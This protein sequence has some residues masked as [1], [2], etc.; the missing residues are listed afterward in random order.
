MEFQYKQ[1]ADNSEWYI[2]MDED[3]SEY[4]LFSLITVPHPKAPKYT[5][6][7]ELIINQNYA[8]DIIENDNFSLLVKICRFTFDSILVITDDNN[9]NECKI[10]A[11]DDL[12][13]GIYKAFA[14]ALGQ[15]HSDYEVT[16]YRRWIV[17]KKL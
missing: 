15:E 7:L 1:A 13:L 6:H 3:N 11:R 16:S 8:E 12:V 5:K 9:M 4:G 14:D 17:V 10:R 2:I